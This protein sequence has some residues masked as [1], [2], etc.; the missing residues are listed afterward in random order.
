MIYILI[1]GGYI[2]VKIHCFNVN[3][4]KEWRPQQESNL[5]L[6]LRKGLLYPSEAGTIAELAVKSTKNQWV[7][8]KL[9]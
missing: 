9:I 2:F 6:P 5:H 1:S 8:L 7:T 3:E 4:Q